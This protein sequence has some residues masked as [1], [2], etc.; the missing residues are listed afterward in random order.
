MSY[1]TWVYIHTKSRAHDVHVQC[2]ISRALPKSGSLTQNSFTT[3]SP[4]SQMFIPYQV[5]SGLTISVD[6][7]LGLPREQK[8]DH[9]PREQKF[10]H[11]P[12]EQKFDHSPREQKFDHSPREQKFD[13]LPREQKFDH[14]SVTLSASYEKRSV[15]IL[16]CCVHVG[17]LFQ[18]DTHNLC[19]CVCVCVCV[20]ACIMYV[21]LHLWCVCMYIQYYCLFAWIYIYIYIYIYMYV[22]MSSI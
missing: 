5:R 15:Q 17:S 12:R 14:F 7:A 6:Y 22:C 13:H 8:F 16:V 9:S 21:Y 2:T 11:S 1:T 19:V 18:Q 4:A 10:D 3:F 20:R